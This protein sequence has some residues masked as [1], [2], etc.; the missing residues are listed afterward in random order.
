MSFPLF[1]STYEDTASA[2]QSANEEDR[3][4]VNKKASRKGP[5]KRYISYLD[6]FMYF[7]LYYIKQAAKVQ[8]EKKKKGIL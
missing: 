6:I 8:R 5:K 3:T 2:S 7:F 1:C 4:S